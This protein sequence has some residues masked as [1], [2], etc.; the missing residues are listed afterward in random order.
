MDPLR[1]KIRT[2]PTPQI[3]RCVLALNRQADTADVWSYER[4][5]IRVALLDEY[6]SRRGTP[7]LDRLLDELNAW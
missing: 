7:A 1:R 5:L 2:M 4:T 6:E 3:R